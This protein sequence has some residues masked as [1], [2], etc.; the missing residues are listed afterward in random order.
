MEYGKSLPN[1]NVI[2]RY[3]AN[4]YGPHHYFKDSL[5]QSKYDLSKVSGR[6]NFIMLLRRCAQKYVLVRIQEKRNKQMEYLKRWA[7]EADC[8]IKYFT[9]HFNGKDAQITITQKDADKHYT[10]YNKRIPCLETAPDKTTVVILDGRLRCGKRVPKKHIGFVWETSKGANT[11]TII[12]SLLGRICGYIGENLYNVPV[13]NKP[14]IFIPERILRRPEKK[15]IVELSDFER[16]IH[17]A[18]TTT[19]TIGPRFATNIVPSSVMNKAIKRHIELTPC[20]PIRFSLNHVQTDSLSSASDNEIKAYCLSKLLD[21]LNLINNNS[22]LKIEQKM[23]IIAKLHSD[24]FTAEDCRIRHYRGDSNKNMHKCHVEAYLDGTA[25]KEHIT[26]FPFLTFCVVHHGFRQLSSVKTTAKSGEVYAI[27]Y[28]EEKGY[29][30]TIHKESRISPVNSKT[31]FTIQP[32]EELLNCIGG[33][34]YGFSTMVLAEPDNMYTELSHFIE[35]AKKGIGIFSKRLTALNNG[36]YILLPRSVYGNNLERF[37]EIIAML[38][39]YFSTKITY[40]VKKRKPLSALL[41]NTLDH[42]IKY[43]SWE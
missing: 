4:Y 26:E 23:E 36:E 21:S 12:Q 39:E 43:I 34:I 15:K 18:A 13:D 5:I 11:D 7:R 14:L 33:G 29:E 22:K 20:V 1:F 37:K 30:S 35:T 38:E 6:H 28:T 40:E 31:H 27:F 10:S 17:G 25:S 19:T 24:G 41:Y 32:T 42:E 16:Y 8:D 2:L 9:S 3:G